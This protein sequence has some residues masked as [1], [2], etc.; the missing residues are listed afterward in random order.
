MSRLIFAQLVREVVEDWVMAALE[1]DIDL[2]YEADGPAMILGNPFLLRELAKNLIDNALRYTPNGGHV[3]C[4]RAGHA[5]RRCSLRLK[6]M[7][8]VSA[9][10][11][12]N[13]SS[14]VSTG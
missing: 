1:K 2:G 6:T 10:S 11:R 7:V 12:P 4:S 13:W 8:S 9:R 3:T 14:S 5:G